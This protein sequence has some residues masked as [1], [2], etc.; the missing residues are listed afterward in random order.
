MEITASMVKELRDKTGAG[1]MDCKKALAE[2][3]GNMEQAVDGLRKKGAA[4]A[5]KRAGRDA[6]EGK[7]ILLENASRAIACEVNCET[8]PV[9]KLEEFQALGTKCAE[10]V[11]N[12]SYADVEALK[13]VSIGSE[14]VGSAW[15][16]MIGKI[17]ENMGVRR[18]GV[19]TKGAGELVATYSHMGGKI[20]IIIKLTVKGNADLSKIQPVAKDLAMQ[21]AASAPVAVRA[22]QVD[23]AIIAK[24]REIYIE[25]ARQAGTKEDFLEK[26]V[27]GK[28]KKFLKESCLEEQGFVKDPKKSVTALLAE[29]AKAAGAESIVVDSFIRFELGK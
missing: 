21:V 20:G 25:L 13:A 14:T 16:M 2:A 24:E 22:A 3:N 4:V 27:D 23:P 9:S 6:K 19:V 7:V 12:G 26:Q 28:V 1:M 29:T 15:E 17:G 10:L 11:L 5:A 18:F 8:E